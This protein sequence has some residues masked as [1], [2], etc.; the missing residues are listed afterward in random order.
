M[1]GKGVDEQTEH[2]GYLG[3][4]NYP[5]R[6]CTSVQTHRTCSIKSEPQLNCG[7]QVIPDSVGSSVVANGPLC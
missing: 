3:Q 2:M 1:E 5:E 7:L 4:W 6:H